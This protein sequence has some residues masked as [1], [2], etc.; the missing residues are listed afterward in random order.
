MADVCTDC[1]AVLAERDAFCPKCGKP[2]ESSTEPVAKRRFCTACGAGLAAETAFCTKCGAVIGERASVPASASAAKTATEVPS[3]TANGVTPQAPASGA[4]KAPSGIPKLALIGGGVIVLLVVLSVVAGVINTAR[5]ARQKAKELEAAAKFEKSLA[6]LATAASKNGNNPP[7]ADIAKSINDM[8]NAANAIAQKTSG[9]SPA[10]INKNVD[11]ITAAANSLTPGSNGI[12][13]PAA[14][15]PATIANLI[16]QNRDKPPSA[17]P[18]SELPA[19]VTISSTAAGGYTWKQGKVTYTWDSHGLR[20]DYDP[21]GFSIDGGCP[22]PRADIM[23][24]SPIVPAAATGNQAHDWALKYE[25]TV[26]GPEADLV[27][28]TGDINNL[29]FGW[30]QGFDPFS[31]QST[32]S[33]SFPWKTPADEPAGTDR[34]MLASILSAGDPRF[35]SYPGD[36]YSAV[37]HNCSCAP[38]FPPCQGRLDSMPQAIT[39]EVGELP[40]QIS[41]V[42]LQ[43]FADDFQAPVFHSHFQVGLNGTR[44]PSFE[45]AI[46]ALEQTGPIGKLV[47]LR[48]LPE[49]WPLLKSGT[50]TLLIDDPTTHVRDGYAIDFARILINPHKFKYQVSLAAHVVD[51]DK[52][53]PVAGAT[54]NAALESAATDREGK[55]ELKGIPAGLVVATASAPGYDEN[56]V[57]VDLVSGQEGS[58]EI[59]LHRHQESTAALEQSI[60]QTGTA[61]IY[62]IHFD[63]DSSKIRGDSIPAL[64]AVRG[65]INNHPGS[66]W[67]I[68]G[69]TDNQGPAAHNQTLSEARAASVVTWL[70]EHGADVSG[71][72]PQGFGATRPV[73][74]N[75][76]ANGRALNRR[77]E[78]ALAK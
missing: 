19:G 33:H 55:C 37:L 10:D 47:S 48:L 14:N 38:N 18:Q 2:R 74:D 50:V 1:G 24:N 3:G 12:S 28:R 5:R 43:I 56:S 51:A 9:A 46:N 17:I 60:A 8:A 57:P 73:A 6:N 32:P 63:T 49:Y 35:Y 78:V 22:L 42:V 36:G 30:P 68:A 44:I 41:N 21:R 72:V 39:L 65:L 62:G 25:R 75:A 15:D 16:W 77:V 23:N 52:H 67:M 29:G 4:V 70:K 34:I 58:A 69:H 20:R 64:D 71:L 54:V 76:T 53:T 11:Q 7:A 61:T 40:P 27:V 26:D 13:S 45:Y 66:H 31:G 59:A